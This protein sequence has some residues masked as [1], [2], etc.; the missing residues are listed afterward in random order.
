MKSTSI[1]PSIEAIIQDMSMPY[2]TVVDLIHLIG[3]TSKSPETLAR[4]VDYV[5][6]N[7]LNKNCI[8]H[9]YHCCCLDSVCFNTYT[10]KAK[11]LN[12]WD[13]NVDQ[14]LNR[15]IPEKNNNEW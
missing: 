13:H 15:I 7:K 12:W 11:L 5:L 1:Y 3:Q 8:S 2:D 9:T 4:I 10:M 14:I 6:E